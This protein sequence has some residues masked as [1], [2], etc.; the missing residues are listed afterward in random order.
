V[1]ERKEKIKIKIKIAKPPY[2]K[3]Q[4]SMDKVQP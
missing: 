4:D 2:S 3:H 1:I